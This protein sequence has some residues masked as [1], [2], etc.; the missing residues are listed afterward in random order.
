MMNRIIFVLASAFFALTVGAQSTPVTKARVAEIR[1]LYTQA[2]QDIA[3]A[4][5]KAKEGAPANETVVNSN[6]MLPG[7]GPGKCATHY[8]YTLKEDENLGRF[9]FTPYFITNS[10]NVAAHKYYQEFLY[11]KEGNLVFYYEKNNQSGKDEETRFYFAQ[12][13]LDTEE[14][15]V[16]EIN[17]GSRQME[18]PFVYRLGS[19][20]LNAFHF[21]MN[22]E[23]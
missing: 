15:L 21:L 14:G 22:R 12:D 16:Y 7:N 6:Y 9:F 8:Y 20:L 4:Q 17:T 11:D 2:K 18:P 10:Y 19:E 13:G 23:F 5:K 3:N 1:K